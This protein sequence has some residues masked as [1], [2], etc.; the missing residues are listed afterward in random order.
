MIQI[1]NI[2]SFNQNDVPWER[3]VCVCVWGGGGGVEG[4]VG[5]P[6]A[7]LPLG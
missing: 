5:G 4:R 2:F 1:V 3:G 6:V 7:T